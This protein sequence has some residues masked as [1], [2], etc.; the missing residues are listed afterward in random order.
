MDFASQPTMAQPW[1]LDQKPFDLQPQQPSHIIRGWERVPKKAATS[2]QKDRKVWKRPESKPY[3]YETERGGAG[4]TIHGAKR[5]RTQNVPAL[6][7]KKG[8]C[9]GRPIEA[10]AENDL[11]AC[12]RKPDILPLLRCTKGCR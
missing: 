10:E 9:R 11:Y 3:E 7:V 6:P 1:Q 4:F 12:R 2:Q 5:V 8:R